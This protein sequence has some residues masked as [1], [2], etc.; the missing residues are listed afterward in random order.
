MLQVL[1]RW[2]I[3]RG[4]QSFSNSHYESLLYP[5][6]RSKES[7]LGSRVEGRSGVNAKVRVCPVVGQQ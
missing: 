5:S 4:S 2:E 1:L 6:P 7:N 3:R